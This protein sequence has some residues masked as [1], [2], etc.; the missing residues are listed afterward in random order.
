MAK[1]LQGQIKQRIEKLTKQINELRFR[2]HVLD[3]PATTD[4]VYDS[5]TRELKT[6]LTEYSEFNTPNSPLNKVAGKP[7]DK[8]IKLLPAGTKVNYFC[9]TKFDGLAVSLIYKE[10]KFM[11]GATRGDGFVGEDI[12]QNL[13]TIN[14]IPLMLP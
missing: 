8:F 6:L 7:L 14:D 13:K 4:E 12:T 10:G 2:Y 9:E 11:R 1:K 5:L 3:D